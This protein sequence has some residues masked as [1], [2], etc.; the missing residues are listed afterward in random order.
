[1][2]SLQTKNIQNITENMIL[3]SHVVGPVDFCVSYIPGDSWESS[4]VDI[5]QS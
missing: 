1:M 4:N 5:N 3:K 2:T